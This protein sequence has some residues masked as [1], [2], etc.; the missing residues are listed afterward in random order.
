MLRT[1][2]RARPKS[3]RL[4]RFCQGR[5]ATCQATLASGRPARARLVQLVALPFFPQRLAADAENRGRLRLVAFHFTQ[6][7]FEIA[8]LDLFKARACGPRPAEGALE[9]GLLERQLVDSDSPAG[10]HD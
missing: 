1:P 6:N 2:A 8:A 7:H 10:V 3:A 4:S 5:R 9:I